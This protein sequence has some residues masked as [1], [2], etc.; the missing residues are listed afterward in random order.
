MSLREKQWMEDDDARTLMRAEEIMSNKQKL[1]G[2]KRGT[3]RIEKEAQKTL[4][5]VKKVKHPKKKK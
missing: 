1:A 4:K 3:K 2:A 5:M